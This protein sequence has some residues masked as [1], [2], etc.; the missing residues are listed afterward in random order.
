[1]SGILFVGWLPH[2]KDDLAEL[3]SKGK[4]A[5]GGGVFLSVLFLSMGYAIFVGIMNIVA[6]GWMGES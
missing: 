2:T 6:P 5:V 4:S 1:M 3:A